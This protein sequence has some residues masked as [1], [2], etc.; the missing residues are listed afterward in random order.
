MPAEDPAPIAQNT[1]KGEGKYIPPNSEEEHD[2][3][4]SP[5][6]YERPQTSTT[7]H[8]L[9]LASIPTSATYLSTLH[10]PIETND[11]P[12]WI[13]TSELGKVIVTMSCESE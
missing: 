1:N 8:I 11:E 7:D 5:Q 2:T 3:P 6:R 4:L 9:N 13:K 12:R 10:S